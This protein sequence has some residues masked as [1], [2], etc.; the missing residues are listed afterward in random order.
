MPFCGKSPSRHRAA[1]TFPATLRSG[2]TFPLLL[3]IGKAEA[4]QLPQ[5]GFVYCDAVALCV[6]LCEEAK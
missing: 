2:G 6:E 4:T 1:R 5:F 3:A